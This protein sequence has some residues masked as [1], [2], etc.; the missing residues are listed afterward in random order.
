[1]RLLKNIEPETPV[2]YVSKAAAN[3][4]NAVRPAFQSAYAIV[5]K[6][7]QVKERANQE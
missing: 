2:K 6:M 3:E 7:E 4:L 1:M 5:N